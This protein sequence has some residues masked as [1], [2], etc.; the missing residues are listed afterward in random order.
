MLLLLL[1]TL[2]QPETAG[3]N[4]F[5]LAPGRAGNI[6]VGI[7]VDQLFSRVGRENTKLLDLQLEG[8][9][10]P[11]IE[12][13]VPGRSRALL[14]EIGEG[15]RISRLNVEDPRFK[16]AQGVGVGSTY[17]ELRRAYRTQAPGHGEGD[18]YVPVPELQMS[19]CFG[20]DYYGRRL[21]LPD[22]AKVTAVLLLP[23]PD[24]DAPEPL[25]RPSQTPLL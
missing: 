16:T 18:V 20:S 21:E 2:G 5:V 11:A 4:D 1:L 19:F 3:T 12:V 22:A 15:F 13:N 24:V 10:R 25:P 7:T 8:M 17:A 14:A 9:F 6:E 23:P